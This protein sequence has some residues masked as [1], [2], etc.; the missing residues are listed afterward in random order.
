MANCSGIFQGQD[1][2]CLDNLAVGLEQ[3]LF[4]ANLADV[5]DITYSATQGEENVITGITMKSGKS[6]FEFAGIA[7]TIKAQNELIRGDLNVSYKH[8]IDLSIFEVDNISL[9]NMQAMA[10][11]NQIAITVGPNDSSLGNGAFQVSGKNVGLE[12]VTNIRIVADVA[13]GAAHVI[14]LSTPEQG[15]TENEIPNPFWVTDYPTTLAALEAL[16]IAAP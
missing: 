10:F 3:R 12:M 1:I 15:G 5:E 16:L 14:Q 9:N 6:F 4:L 13:T 8:T 7:Q 11:K 2:D